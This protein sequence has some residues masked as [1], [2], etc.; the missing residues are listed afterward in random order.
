MFICFSGFIIEFLKVL[1][2]Y[3]ITRQASVD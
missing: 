3:T 2:D 1:N